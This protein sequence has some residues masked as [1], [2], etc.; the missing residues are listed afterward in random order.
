MKWFDI[1][2][3]NPVVSK[4]EICIFE[5]IAQDKASTLGINHPVE[6]SSR[7]D[8]HVPGRTHGVICLRTLEG[9]DCGE[10]VAGLVEGASQQDAIAAGLFKKGSSV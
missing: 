10:V 7:A 1:L 4:S 2:E 3:Y 5:S 8:C 6:C 9:E